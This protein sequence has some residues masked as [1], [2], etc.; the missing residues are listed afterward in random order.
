MT[1][2]SLSSPDDLYALTLTLCILKKCQ[3]RICH[4][5]S[6]GDKNVGLEVEY[7]ISGEVTMECTKKTNL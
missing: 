6:E 5:A 4:S 2:L 1:S 7:E 3:V